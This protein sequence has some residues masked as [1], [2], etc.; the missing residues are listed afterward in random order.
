MIDWGKGEIEDI[1]T[2]SKIV[3]RVVKE[4]PQAMLDYMTSIMDLQAC[5]THGCA[6]DLD[7]MKEAK[8]GDLLHDVCGI[9]NHLDRETGEL[10]NCFLPRFAKRI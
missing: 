10:T 1:R 5:H 9:N 7:R 3:K 2:I 4:H 8:T 6:L